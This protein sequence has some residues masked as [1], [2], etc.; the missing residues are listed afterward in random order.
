MSLLFCLAAAILNKLFGDLICIVQ[1]YHGDVVKFCGDALLC[2]FTKYG[3]S[4]QIRAAVSCSLAIHKHDLQ[5]SELQAIRF[6]I[7]AFLFAII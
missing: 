1:K 4:D 2:T 5:D 6:K 3:F 7:G